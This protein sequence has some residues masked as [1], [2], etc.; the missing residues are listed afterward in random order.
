MHQSPFVRRIAKPVIAFL[1]ALTVIIPMSS[2][3]SA[4]AAGGEA[5]IRV[6]VYTCAVYS[7]IVEESEKQCYLNYEQIQRVEGF[8]QYDSWAVYDNNVQP[9]YADGNGLYYIRNWWWQFDKGVHVTLKNGD[10]W[11]VQTSPVYRGV[12]N[13]GILY[14]YWNNTYIGTDITTFPTDNF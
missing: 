9:C 7:I 4:A 13:V 11:T 2:A 1:L 12:L 14:N 10:T 5:Q 8:N 3:R 6:F